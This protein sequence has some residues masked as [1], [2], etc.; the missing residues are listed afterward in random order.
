MTPI[1]SFVAVLFLHALALGQG[2]IVPEP[3][4]VPIDRRHGPFQQPV[5]T[6]LLQ[7]RTT[8]ADGATTTELE[9]TLHNRTGAQQEAWWLLPLPAG[10][11]ADRFTMT[12]GG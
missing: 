1:R 7:I 9:Q 11:T 5:E 2:V 3:V 12:V 6:G 10:A 4:P 8:I